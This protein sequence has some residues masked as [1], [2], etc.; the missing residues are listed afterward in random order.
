MQA[1]TRVNAEQASKSAMWEPTRLNDGEGRRPCASA[2]DRRH[3]GPTGVMASAC[4]KGEI[5]RNTGSLSG[6]RSVRETG[7]PR[8]SG[9]AVW[10]GGEARSSEEA[11]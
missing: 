4:M 8:G 10:G 11:G 2:S 6:F 3:R 1:E 5:G 9:R 7:T